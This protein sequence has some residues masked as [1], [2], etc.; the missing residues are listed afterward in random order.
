MSDFEKIIIP[1]AVEDIKRK[2]LTEELGFIDS[3]T[4]D[5]DKPWD[6]IVFS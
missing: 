2:D 5:E 4:Y 6:R 1:L 3:Y